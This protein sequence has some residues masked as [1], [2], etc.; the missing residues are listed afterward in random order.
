MSERIRPNRERSHGP[1]GPGGVFD[2]NPANQ[3]SV[4]VSSGPYAEHLPVGNLSV[5]EIRRRFGDRFDLDPQS[6]AVLD[7]NDVSDDVVVRPGQSLTFVRRAGE[8][9]SST[10]APEQTAFMEMLMNRLA[11]RRQR[12]SLEGSR[13]SV[14]GNEATATSPEGK[15]A[16]MSLEALLA[17]F[18]PS[19]LGT[20]EAV[21][22]DGVKTVRGDGSVTVWVHETAPA[23]HRLVWL[24][25]DSPVPYGRGA[26]YR[27]VSLAL[28]YL[29][30]FCVFVPGPGGLPMLSSVN[31]CFFRNAPLKSLDDE[32]CYPAL[33]NCSKFDPPDGRPLSWICT[34]YLKH[35]MSQPVEDQSRR[36]A[37]SF[38]ALK[39]CLL[40]TGFN[41]SSE[42]H[43][44]SSWFTESRKVDPRI[45]TVE[46]W[47]AASRQDS[48][49]VLEVPWLSTGHTARQAIE[50]IFKNQQRA[51]RRPCTAAA[52]ARVIFNQPK[53]RPELPKPADL[54]LPHEMF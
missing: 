37:S 31:E 21:L 18:A 17:R 4:T 30:I 24:A 12:S 19:E 49:F 35:Q 5:G 41:Y 16:T 2:G 20:G 42:H 14:E 36:L 48:L 1:P 8:K 15:T 34:Q 52:L 51:P 39:H 29:L 11:H 38:S 44:T 6:Q 45:N 22:P 47:E 3:P 54:T 26:R 40:E 27:E 32:L 46:A 9:G 23:V 43:E 28:P 53:A 10:I 25:S 50:R 13:V 33:L 7:G